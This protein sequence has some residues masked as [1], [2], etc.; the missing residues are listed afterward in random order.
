MGLCTVK[1][2]ISK[3]RIE[4]NPMHNSNIK[5]NWEYGESWHPYY[6]YKQ[7]GTLSSV[8]ETKRFYQRLM[9]RRS[10]HLEAIWP[11]TAKYS[12]TKRRTL[13]NRKKT[14]EICRIIHQY[15]SAGRVMCWSAPQMWLDLLIVDRNIMQNPT[16]IGSWYPILKGHTR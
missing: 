9:N 15:P 1:G 5:L 11:E 8:N 4:S 7:T 14:T 10:R 2:K 13:H 6:I 3:L 16:N 12:W